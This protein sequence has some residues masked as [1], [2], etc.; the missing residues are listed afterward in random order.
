MEHIKFKNVKTLNV[1]DFQDV[2]H[3]I[4]VAELA[5][6]KVYLFEVSQEHI[7][8]KEV[9]S[10][11]D[12]LRSSNI[13]FLI[14]PEGGIINGNE[15]LDINERKEK[16]LIE[17]E[18]L[19]IGTFDEGTFK[20]RVLSDNN[21]IICYVRNKERDWDKLYDHLDKPMKVKGSIMT[22]DYFMVTDI[23]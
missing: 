5:G 12:E 2:F 15:S 11:A 9:K 19:E 16:K 4:S 10:F 17:L 1:K 3:T 8:S 6:E 23:C 20:A 22:R 13:R 7:M 18:I 14:V 21:I